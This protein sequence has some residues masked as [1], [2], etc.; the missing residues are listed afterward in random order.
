MAAVDPR[1]ELENLIHQTTDHLRE[2]DFRTTFSSDDVR[3][4]RG[5]SKWDAFTELVERAMLGLEGSTLATKRKSRSTRSN[6]RLYSRGIA[7]DKP[8]TRRSRTRGGYDG[9][10]V[11]R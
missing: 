5:I 3:Q 10:H 7:H 11:L 4:L 1:L 6:V 8:R 2:C 9:L